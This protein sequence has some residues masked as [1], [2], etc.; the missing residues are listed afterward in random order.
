[1][2]NTSKNLY[3]KLLGRKGEDLAYIYL[4]K[5]GYKIIETNYYTKFAEADIIALKGD[6]LTFV[7]VKTRTSN[8]YG[9]PSEAVN[10]KK[11]EKYRELALYYVN[12]K[13]YDGEIAFAVV[14]VMGTS[15]NFIENAF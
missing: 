6:V 15:V 9:A 5:L 3:K 12:D 8:K 7:E 13:N 11:Q 14:E 10:K 2:Q 4:K 1:M